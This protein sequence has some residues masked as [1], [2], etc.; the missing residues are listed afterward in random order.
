MQMAWNISTTILTVLNSRYHM[1]F[2]KKTRG[3]KRGLSKWSISPNRRFQPFSDANLHVLSTKLRCWSL[4]K[5]TMYLRHEAKKTCHRNLQTPSPPS[6]KSIQFDRRIY[7]STYRPVSIVTTAWSAS[8]LLK[9]ELPATSTAVRLI[10]TLSKRCRKRGLDRCRSRSPVSMNTY[11]MKVAAIGHDYLYYIITILAS[12]LTIWSIYW[13]P[14]TGEYSHTSKS[15]VFHQNAAVSVDFVFSLS[16][17]GH[18][19]LCRPTRGSCVH[20]QPD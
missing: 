16:Q 2:R 8:T 20:L 1:V 15:R 11:T 3:Q 13:N 9:A 5:G 18:M 17:C 12:T 6:Q 19:V 14:Y 4:L 7:Y 10:C